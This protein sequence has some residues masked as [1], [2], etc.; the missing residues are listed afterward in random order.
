M[1]CERVG[2]VWEGEGGRSLSSRA[3][4]LVLSV[5]QI[6]RVGRMDKNWSG[7]PVRVDARTGRRGQ[8]EGRGRDAATTREDASCCAVEDEWERVV[9]ASER[10]ETGTS[11]DPIDPIDRDAAIQSTPPKTNPYLSCLGLQCHACRSTRILTSR[12]AV[13]PCHLSIWPIA[14]SLHHFSADSGASG[15]AV[16]LGQST[17]MGTAFASPSLEPDSNWHTP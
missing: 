8:R 4:Q 17:H 11:T 13:Q 2:G 5:D 7:G 9:N 12:T 3:A 1:L 10:A 14:S 15:A 16:L 6:R